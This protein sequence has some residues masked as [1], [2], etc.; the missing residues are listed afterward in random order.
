MHFSPF[1]LGSK[2]R[3]VIKKHIINK[4]IIFLLII[5]LTS[6]LW[7]GRIALRYSAL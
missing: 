4:D 7:G 6:L 2:K 3:L 5:C 1:A